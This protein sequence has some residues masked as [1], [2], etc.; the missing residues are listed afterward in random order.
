MSGVIREKAL[1]GQGKG[2]EVELM[3]SGTSVYSTYETLDGF[4]A[5]YDNALELFCYA[6]VVNG[7]YQSTGVPVTAPPP[8]S[9]QRHAAESDEVRAE[10]IARRQ[11]QLDRAASIDKGVDSI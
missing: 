7:A 8:A 3:V 2:P 4:S 11:S 9:A 1:L 10:K 6:T 5:V